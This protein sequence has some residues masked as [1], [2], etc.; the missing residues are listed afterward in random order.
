MG[1]DGMSSLSDELSNGEIVLEILGG[2]EEDSFDPCLFEE[3]KEIGRNFLDRLRR[4][5][6]SPE[7]RLQVNG[8]LSFPH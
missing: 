8:Y 4:L 6:A 2:K 5:R 1:T 3:V 7:I